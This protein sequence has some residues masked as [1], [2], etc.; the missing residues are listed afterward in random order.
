MKNLFNRNIRNRSTFLFI[1]L[2]LLISILSYGQADGISDTLTF[3]LRGAFYYS[4]YPQTWT[5]GGK[6][7]WYSV[8]L[9]YYSSD[10][11]AVI[12]QHI[13]DMEYAK[14][15][16]AIASWW[17]IDAQNQANRFPMLLNQTISAGSDLKWAIYYEDEGFDNPSVEELKSDL[18]YLMETYA[19][20]EA[21]ARV[22]GKPVVF[23]YNAN[24]N[25]NDVTDRWSQ[26]TN[27]EW[28]V[29]LKVFGGFRNCT[30]QPD[31]WHQY[32]PDAP[33]QQHSGYSYVIA[34]GFWRADM[35]A[36]LLVR[37]VNRWNKNVRDMVA[38]GE[39]WQLITTYNEWGEGTAIE[40]CLD[41]QS[42]S[43]YGVYLDAL[44]NDGDGSTLIKESANFPAD[45]NLSQNFPNP[46]NPSTTIIYQIPTASV[47][48]LQV[49]DVLGRE[50]KTL[51]DEYKTAGQHSVEFSDPSLTSGVYY[52]RLTAANYST[53][54]KMLLVR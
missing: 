5:V 36:P 50:V 3:P 9:G 17:G 7:V 8:E 2:Q 42:N 38:S 4:W 26:A 13:Q 43:G 22:D 41:W 29:N 24:D 54:R 47:V 20:H 16:V 46:F 11:P 33:A 1:L 31:S 32:G 23:V 28:Y 27:G 18:S 14:I 48:K 35:E 49:F 6:H 12:E 10:D 44:H 21:F 37:D 52:Y 53:V 40:R 51:V 39:P 15:D 30:N 34:P 25:S 19:S 45:F